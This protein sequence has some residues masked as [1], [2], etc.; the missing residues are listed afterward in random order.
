LFS[1]AKDGL[2][3]LWDL[4]RQQCVGTYGD[5][6]ISKVNDFAMIGELAMLVVGGTDNKLVIFDL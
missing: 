3:K 5:P 6:S 1:G 4:D 2:V